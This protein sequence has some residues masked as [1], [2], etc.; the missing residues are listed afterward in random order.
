MPAKS[1]WLRA[2]ECPVTFS[3]ARIIALSSGEIS[4]VHNGRAIS[5]SRSASDRASRDGEIASRLSYA[6]RFPRSVA[7]R[8]D[9]L[10]VDTSLT[11]RRALPHCW[12]P[13]E[14]AGLPLLGRRD[15]FV[16]PSS[17]SLCLSLSLFLSCPVIPFSPLWTTHFA[18]ATHVSRIFGS[19]FFIVI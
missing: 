8:N 2:E 1:V 14:R 6:L 7:P 11:M 15:A 10:T 13:R 16:L 12:K 19:L 5:D 4:V 9:R 18:L 17:S 3:M